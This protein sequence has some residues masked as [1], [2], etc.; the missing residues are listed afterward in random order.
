VLS[1]VAE[2][3]IIDDELKGGIEAALK[4]FGQ[5]FATLRGTAAVA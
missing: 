1:G 3:K 4:D 2:K 5:H